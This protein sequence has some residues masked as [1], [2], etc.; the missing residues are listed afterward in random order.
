MITGETPDI[1]EYVD[2]GFYDW[3]LFCTN[4]GL[5]EPSLGRWIGVSHKIGQLMS[6]WILPESG[7]PIS[8]VTVQKMTNAEKE[9]VEYIKLMQSFD[10]KLQKNIEIK[11]DTSNPPDGTP[12]WNRLSTNEDDPAFKDHFQQVISN[13]L[14]PDVDSSKSGTTTP[15]EYI[16]MELGLPRGRDHT[17]EYAK[18]K[19]RALDVDGI[20]I[21]APSNNPMTDSR[22]YDVEYMD[23]TIESVAANVIA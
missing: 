7:K 2:F 8:C 17:L 23:G 18:V 13:D 10:D 11:D 6:Y 1:S 4:S 19:R 5:G 12:D 14:I 16:N 9:K 22:I 15:D 21:G 3:V 20:P